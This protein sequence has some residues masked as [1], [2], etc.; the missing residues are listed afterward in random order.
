MDVHKKVDFMHLNHKVAFLLLEICGLLE[1]QVE[2]MKM[3]DSKEIFA[4]WIIRMKSFR[5]E[6][7]IL[8]Y[9]S[10]QLDAWFIFKRVIYKFIRK[11]KKFLCN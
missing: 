2:R 3:N 10:F 4:S 8:T 1:V 6:W 11:S 7:N 9:K 5:L